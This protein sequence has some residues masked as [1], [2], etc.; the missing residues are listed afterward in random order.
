MIIFQNPNLLGL[1]DDFAF[2]CQSYK[3]FGLV[4][5]GGANKLERLSLENLPLFTLYLCVRRKPMKVLH[6]ERL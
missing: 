5:H 1:A 2:S 6:L 4:T 3:T